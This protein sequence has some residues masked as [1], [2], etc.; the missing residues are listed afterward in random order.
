[1]VCFL[2]VTDLEFIP[3]STAGLL[4]LCVPWLSEL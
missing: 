1:M 2:L 4:A 3:L